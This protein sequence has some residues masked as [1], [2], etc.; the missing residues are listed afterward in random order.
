MVVA[1]SL[2]LRTV[3][4]DVAFHRFTADV[5]I[6]QHVD[7]TVASRRVKLWFA[8][9]VNGAGVVHQTGVNTV[10]VVADLVGVAIRINLT[11]H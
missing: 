10:V 5:G 4:V 7:G 1:A 8:D 2:V 9:G 3:H 11:L 6:A